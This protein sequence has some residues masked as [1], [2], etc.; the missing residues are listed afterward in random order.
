M[1]QENLY[2]VHRGSFSSLISVPLWIID[3]GRE[4]KV[5]AIVSYCE[6]GYCLA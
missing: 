2:S 6:C 3:K 1:G 5:I 4:R